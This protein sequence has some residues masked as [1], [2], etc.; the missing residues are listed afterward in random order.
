ME[1]GARNLRFRLLAPFLSHVN[2]TVQ[3][4]PSFI[5]RE[6]IV[7]RE[8]GVEVFQVRGPFRARFRTAAWWLLAGGVG[9]A[10]G[11]WVATRSLGVGGTGMLAF[12]L[13]AAVFAG[14]ARSVLL[15]TEVPPAGDSIAVRAVGLA[16]TPRY[17]VCRDGRAVASIRAGPRAHPQY[18]FAVEVYGREP[19]TATATGTGQYTLARAE[20]V[21]AVLSPA[22]NQG[23]FRISIGREED[24]GLILASALAIRLLHRPDG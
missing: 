5:R 18:R 12:L 3:A 2:Y 17:V 24:P 15:A 14:R 21:V 11:V 10:A 20:G 7:R 9:S 8:G 1:N 22:E 16:P 6:F 19:I 23:Q 4:L 13:A